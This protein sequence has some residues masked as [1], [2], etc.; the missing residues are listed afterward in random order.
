MSKITL[1]N[2][3]KKFTDK[4]KTITHILHQI[5][6]EFEES[7]I[8]CILGPSGCGKTTLINLLAGY[9]FPDDGHITCDNEII[10]G[11]N[12]KRAVVFQDHALFL[13][14]TVRKNIEFGLKCQKINNWERQN[15]VDEYIKKFNLH[16]FD[17]HYPHQ[18]SGGM[19]QWVGLARVL[20]VKPNVLLMDEPFSS[21]DEQ[22]RE[23]LQ[24]NLLQI[25][26]ENKPTIIFVT[27]NIDEA[28]F[29][30]DTIIIL[31]KRPGTIKSII[32]VPFER[33]RQY[34][35][36]NLPEFF[37]CRQMIWKIIRD[38]IN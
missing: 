4:N 24:E 14:K 2:V 27:H 32:K 38:E 31:T 25:H 21:L 29:L 18:L 26:E 37:Q 5:S 11:P 22:N 1:N 7:K 3:S 15:I 8:I 20:A 16:G 17:N 12:A 10:K 28:I 19:K 34:K 33:P 6:F 23:F 13:W 35:I 36:R 9:I 30:A